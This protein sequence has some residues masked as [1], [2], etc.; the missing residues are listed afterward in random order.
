LVTWEKPE[1]LKS[2]EEIRDDSDEWKWIKDDLKMFYPARIIQYRTKG[3]LVD[4]ENLDGERATVK[5]NQINTTID[6]KKHMIADTKEDLVLLENVNA[7]SIIHNVR[8]RYKK[9]YT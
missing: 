4:I 3:D 1:A 9:V 8:E 5:T 2:S 6:L 7:A